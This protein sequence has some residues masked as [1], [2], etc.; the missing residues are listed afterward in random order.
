MNSSVSIRRLTISAMLIAVG[1]LLPFVTAQIQLIGN[2]ISPMH[3]PVFICGLLCGPLWGLAVGAI[4]PILRSFL[5]GMPPLMP[6]AVAMMF[7]LAAYGL[8]SGLLRA[9]LPKTMPML[10]AALGVSMVLGRIVWGMASFF[11][12]GFVARSFTW[13]LFLTNGF[14]NAIPGIVLQF[15]LIPPIVRALEKAKL[16]Q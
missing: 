6:T 1:L 7:E 5:F 12:Y 4:V 14:L 10:Y 3:Y 9:K 8:F 11:V 2:I 13:Q 16:A 15:I